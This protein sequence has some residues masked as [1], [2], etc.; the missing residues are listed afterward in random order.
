[1]VVCIASLLK[2]IVPLLEV[3]FGLAKLWLY[4]LLELVKLRNRTS[5]LWVNPLLVEAVHRLGRKWP[6]NVFWVV[7]VKIQYLR[8]DFIY[9]VTHSIENAAASG[10]FAHEPQRPLSSATSCKGSCVMALVS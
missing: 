2:E 8:N 5:L 6:K 10:R 1:M 9:P 7:M 4:V 3:V